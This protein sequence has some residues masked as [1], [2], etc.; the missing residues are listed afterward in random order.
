MWLRRIVNVLLLD[1]FLL[2]MDA[3]IYLLIC[4]TVHKCKI[5]FII[6]TPQSDSRGGERREYILEEICY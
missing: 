3:S 2:E 1:I 6:I 4:P 5:G